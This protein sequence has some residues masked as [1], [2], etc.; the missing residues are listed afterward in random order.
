MPK[1]T[2]PTDTTAAVGYV[3]TSTGRQGNSIAAQ[4]DAIER[5]AHRAGL[6]V[7]AVQQDAGVSG[8]SAVVERDG[9]NA[10]VA[11]MRES[12]ACA[13]IVAKRDRLARDLIQSAL[14]TRL[15]EWMGA[16]V[17]SADGSGNADGPEGTLLAQMLDAFAQFERALIA[18]RTRAALRAR[19]DRCQKFSRFPPFGWRW[20]RDGK[21]REDPAQQH[22][23]RRMKALRRRGLSHRAI[24]AKLDGEGRG[25]ARAARWGLGMVRSLCIRHAP[26]T[27]AAKQ[28]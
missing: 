1:R 25:P 10:A 16:K 15:V 12:G 19:R 23:L 2:R 8:A 13:L 17:L 5:F 3:R 24:G 21:M 27:T 18:G 9:F 7:V 4:R 20:T 11:E 6:R 22:T 14:A 26:L 28:V